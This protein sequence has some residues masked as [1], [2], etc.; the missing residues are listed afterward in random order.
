M[1]EK[2]GVDIKGSFRPR[3]DV[4]IAEVANV[5]LR[6][7][8]LAEEN[9]GRN[10]ELAAK[11]NGHVRSLATN[12]R[13]IMGL[14]VCRSLMRQGLSALTRAAGVTPELSR[15]LRVMDTTGPSRNA[16]EQDKRDRLV[17]TV[18]ESKQG[19]RVMLDLIRAVESASAEVGLNDFRGNR[20]KDLELGDELIASV[21]S[22]EMGSRKGQVRYSMGGYLPKG[23][24]KADLDAHKTRLAAAYK[25]VEA[26]EIPLARRVINLVKMPKKVYA[27]RTTTVQAATHQMEAMAAATFHLKSTLV[28]AGESLAEKTGKATTGNRNLFD[29]AQAGIAANLA[30]APY[31]PTLARAIDEDGN[32]IVPKSDVIGQVGGTLW[33]GGSVGR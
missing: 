17:D 31:Q 6:W 13:S 21:I 23:A 29:V 15:K 11:L 18:E 12:L 24:S 20:V 2:F 9:L 26:E 32:T 19:L 25:K 4:E 7:M 5:S 27:D 10:P 28:I 3:T 1:K 14:R 33:T 16:D 8:G 30:Q 22:L